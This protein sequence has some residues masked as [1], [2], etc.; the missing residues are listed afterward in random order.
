MY[1]LLYMKITP[2]WVKI[3][4]K[5]TRWCPGHFAPQTPGGERV[6]KDLFRK[7]S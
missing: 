3:E 1:G 7:P 2:S 6:K 4:I 5:K